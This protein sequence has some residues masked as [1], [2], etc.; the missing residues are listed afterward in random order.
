M[1]NNL[2]LWGNIKSKFFTEAVKKVDDSYIKYLY[3]NV[4][5]SSTICKFLEILKDFD[6]CTKIEEGIFEFTIVYVG[7]KNY[8]L[9]FLPA[10]YNDKVIELV[11]NLK[12]GNHLENK[13]LKEALKKKYIDS[14]TLAFLKPQD[15][16]PE[17]WGLIIRKNDLRNE[18]K[19]NMAT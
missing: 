7:S 16:H 3:F 6:M 17:R 11:F 8:P 9:T 12:N 15:I 1:A 13:T 18:K 5:R 19:N 14:R 4:N 2:Q 10:I